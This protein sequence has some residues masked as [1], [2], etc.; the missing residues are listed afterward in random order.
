MGDYDGFLPP[1]G[2]GAEMTS[3]GTPALGY[4]SFTSSSSYSHPSSSSYPRPSPSSR[5]ALG[6][7]HWTRDDI[8]RIPHHLFILHPEAQRMDQEILGLKARV[9]SL[10][11]TNAQLATSAAQLSALTAQST[12]TGNGPR[13][14]SSSGPR[15]YNSASSYEDQDGRIFIDGEDL[16]CVPERSLEELPGAEV[17]CWTQAHAQQLH[18]NCQ[19]GKR[20]ITRGAD[21]QVIDDDLAAEIEKVVRFACA[22]LE[23]IKLP[24]Y[25]KNKPRTFELYTMYFL[26]DV[27]RVCVKLEK[28]CPPL[29]YCCL[30]Y[31]ALKWIQKH[32]KA[33]VGSVAKAKRK[34]EKEREVQPN[35]RRRATQAEAQPEINAKDKGKEKEKAPR[36]ASPVRQARHTPA[37]APKARQQQDSDTSM[38]DE[39]Y[40]DD[41]TI[42]RAGVFTSSVGSLLSSGESTPLVRM[43]ATF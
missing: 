19:Y 10:E 24:D 43:Y 36:M 3:A 20:E 30:H 32:L 6:P 15:T 12:A 37:P 33:K 28:T 9:T 26:P 34:Y 16:S 40:S 22:P 7:D 42:R 21:G 5:Y 17:M 13:N 35:K 39:E 23:A 8:V 14:I 4:T 41:V 25:L 2:S 1:S 11:A 31:K 38:S 18:P 29:S 27:L